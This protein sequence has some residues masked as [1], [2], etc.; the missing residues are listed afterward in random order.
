MQLVKFAIIDKRTADFKVRTDSSSMSEEVLWGYFKND[1]SVISKADFMKAAKVIMGVPVDAPA[2]IFTYV[3]E[4]VDPETG[5]VFENKNYSYDDFMA[6]VYKRRA[7][8]IAEH[9]EQCQYRVIFSLLDF[10]QN[11]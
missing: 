2:V 10:L 1:E 4:L 5:E 6:D 3:D 11:M 9:E 8:L 7:E